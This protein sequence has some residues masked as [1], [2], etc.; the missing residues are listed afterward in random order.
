MDIG[1]LVKASL[2]VNMIRADSEGRLLVEAT[3]LAISE[4]DRNA[5]AEA[6][7]IK[8]EIGGKIYIYSVLTW[9][10]LNKRKSE[11][12]NVMREALALGGDEAHVV[13]D[14]KLISGDTYTTAKALA[15]LIDKVARCE[16]ILTGEGSMDMTSSQ[17]PILLAGYLGYNV[18]TYARKIDLE[19][20]LIRVTRDLEDNLEVIETSLP[21][22]V[23]VTGEINR[24]KL[25][26]L[27]QIRRAFGKPYNVY[28]LSTLDIEIEP[29]YPYKDL[30]IVTVTRKNI[31]IEG[32]SLDDI[33]V[34]LVD[35]LIEE[36]VIK[37]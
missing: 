27:L 30:K 1:V 17:I 14:E 6:L 33:A 4:Y 28:D 15:K 12:E 7:R 10:P 3:P 22:V 26:T 16:L 37:V 34:K 21:S 2:D 19:D 24:P 35:K 11:I 25:P 5:V 9:G 31:I 29:R 13:V 32:D 18:I 20:G 8:N 36:G 23:S